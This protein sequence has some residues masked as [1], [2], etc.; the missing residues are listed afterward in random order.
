MTPI[1]NLVT[2]VVNISS[3]SQ[4]PKC[5]QVDEVSACQLFEFDSSVLDE[6]TIT[7]SPLFDGDFSLVGNVDGNADAF[8]YKKTSM[9]KNWRYNFFSF[10]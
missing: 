10:F 2:E 7:L 1:V 8:Y 3:P 5:C 6:N 9:G 4:R